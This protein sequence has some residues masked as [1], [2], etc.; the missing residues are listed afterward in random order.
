[1]LPNKPGCKKAKNFTLIKLL[2]VIAIIAIL[3]AIIAAHGLNL[4][5]H[6]ITLAS[7]PDLCNAVKD[8]QL[9][10]QLHD[11]AYP[12]GMQS[13]IPPGSDNRCKFQALKDGLALKTLLLNNNSGAQL[14]FTVTAQ[15][16]IAS[17]LKIYRLHWVCGAPDYPELLDRFQVVEIAS[18]QLAG[19]LLEFDATGV[20]PGTY[21]GEI[22]VSPL[23]D[24]RPIRKIQCQINVIDAHL[25][26]HDYPHLMGYEYSWNTNPG[27]LKLM[28]DQRIDT[29]HIV[30]Y[31]KDDF[32]PL[33]KFMDEVNK[34]GSRNKIKQLWI[35]PRFVPTRDGSG[36]RN[37]PGWVP[38]CNA[39]LDHLRS[40]LAKDGFG[41]HD[42]TMLTYDECEVPDFI[43]DLKAIRA[44]NS[45]IR[46][47]SDFNTED[48]SVYEKYAPYM[49]VW[50]PG[51]HIFLSP[52]FPKASQWYRANGNRDG[53]ELWT[54]FC[55]ATAQQ[56]ISTY[57]IHGWIGWRIG[58]AGLAFYSCKPCSLRPEDPYNFGMCYETSPG[59]YDPSRR[60]RVWRESVEDYRILKTAFR[61]APT[62]T[63]ALADKVIEAYMLRDRNPALLSETVSNAREKLLEI[64]SHKK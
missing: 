41:D 49:T 14:N 21:T 15:G 8:D 60:W 10:I 31:K 38:E 5:N 29:F 17:M 40:E 57:Q 27:V 58:A 12:F 24:H 52:D 59:V 25:D 26:P 43:R 33:Y 39:W 47:H 13:T 4:G 64:I 22:I 32:S 44:H 62:Q 6:T 2:V 9:S 55:D 34:A 63:Q 20:K 18:A 35:E 61:I 3:A 36:L 19:L 30:L 1:M 7:L 11:T 37:N 50:M 42:W 56:S 51:T 46:T 28:L 23:D 48:I 16:P 53:H 54:Y 45:Q